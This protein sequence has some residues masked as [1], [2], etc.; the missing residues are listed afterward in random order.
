[1]PPVETGSKAAGIAVGALQ[2]A[3]EAADLF[4]QFASAEHHVLWVVDLLPHERVVYVS[5]A[6]ETV[7]GRRAEELYA[8]SRL[9]ACAIHP[10]D[11]PRVNAAF[12]R[13]ID[14]PA[15]HRFDLEYRI[16]RPDGSLRWIHDRGQAPV[17]SAKVLG[18]RTG[19]AE[20]ISE[21]RIALDALRIEQQRLGA[22]AEVAPSVLHTFRRDVDGHSSFP[23]AALGWR[24]CMACRPG[25]STPT[26]V[27]WPR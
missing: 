14:N 15:V 5:P 4:V 19:I 17:A 7:W 20:D 9:W 23:T 24:S 18:R 11:Q 8:D 2:S 22:I 10:D 13:W 27:C 12:G 16:V 25:P 26:P 21:R 1:M 3:A 6:F